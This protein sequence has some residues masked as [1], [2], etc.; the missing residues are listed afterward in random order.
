MARHKDSAERA[1]YVQFPYGYG[2]YDIGVQ[3][4]GDKCGGCYQQYPEYGRTAAA[5]QLRGHFADCGY[6]FDWRALEHITVFE[7]L[8]EQ[9]EMD[10]DIDEIRV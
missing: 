5:Y 1:G 3:P 9:L 2:Y 7:N 8:A 10:I 4:G 6:E